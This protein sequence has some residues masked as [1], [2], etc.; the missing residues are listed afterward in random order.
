MN[1]SRYLLDTNSII[2]LLKKNNIIEEN[3]TNAEWVGTSVICVIE[4]LSFSNLSSEDVALLNNLLTR[5]E[6]LEISNNLSTL[7]FFA[8]LKKKNKL[9]LPDAIIAGHAIQ[10]K[11]ILVTADKHFLGIDSLKLLVYH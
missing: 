1:G 10:N 8:D 7:D 9:K 11:A 6:I 2:A 3:L 4:F 5:I